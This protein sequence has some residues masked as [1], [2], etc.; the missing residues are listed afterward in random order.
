VS[1]LSDEPA[2]K[3]ALDDG[4]SLVLFSGD[5][6][7]GGPQCG[8]IAGKKELV[9]QCARHPLMRAL[10]P[11]SHTLLGLQEVLLQYLSGTASSNIAFWKMA[12]CSVS[13]LRDR[14]IAVL[15]KVQ[16]QVS[17]ADALLEIV[18]TAALPGAG[19][20]PGASIPSVAITIKGDIV[21]QLRGYSTP[22]IARQDHNHT[23][24]DMRS[25]LPIDDD[26]VV[27]AL[28]HALL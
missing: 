15:Q 11:G 24:I 3:Q 7:L 4:A 20:A 5:K 12:T 23:V 26:V 6:L 28:I 27:N 14:A 19:S 21:E 16:S 9:E 1:W 10:R 13:D 17:S 25:F 22:V 18:D 2:A 8:V